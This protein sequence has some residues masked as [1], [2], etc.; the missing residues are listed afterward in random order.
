MSGEHLVEVRLAMP[1]GELV[2]AEK[3][4]G[5]NMDTERNR[6]LVEEFVSGLEVAH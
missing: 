1:E 4:V 6:R 2:A 5:E 3:I